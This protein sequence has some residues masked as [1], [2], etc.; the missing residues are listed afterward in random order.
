MTTP[1]ITCQYLFD[2]RKDQT[3]GTSSIWWSMGSTPWSG[4]YAAL[5]INNTDDTKWKDGNVEYNSK[6]KNKTAQRRQRIMPPSNFGSLS[7]ISTLHDIAILGEWPILLDLWTVIMPPYIVGQS[8]GAT[9]RKVFQKTPKYS[10]AGY[11]NTRLFPRG[12]CYTLKYLLA[13]W[14]GQDMYQLYRKTNTPMPDAL[15]AYTENVSFVLINKSLLSVKM[16]RLSP[17]DQ[18][19]VMQEVDEH[20]RTL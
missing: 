5:K 18:K 17:D 1:H 16:S 7:I 10:I 9:C 3:R 4:L 8:V 19:V 11:L 14:T 13:K 20:I 12:K 2:V 6:S 15:K